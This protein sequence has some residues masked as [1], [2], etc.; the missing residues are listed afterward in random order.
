M[1]L[2][3]I[4]LAA[5]QGTRMRSQQPKVLHAIAGKSML[6]RVV[7]TAQQLNPQEIFVI[8]GY[9]GNLLR[10][11]LAHLNVTWVEQKEQLGTGHAVMQATPKIPDD[12]RVLV[13]YGD[14]PLISQ[15]TLEKLMAPTSK[16][17]IGMITAN[18]EDPA[19]L[20]RIVRDQSGNFIEIVEYK[21]A[22]EK[23]RS[24]HEINSGIYSFPA[25][26]LKAWLPKLSVENAQKEYYLTDVLAM[27]VQEGMAVATVFPNSDHEVMGVNDRVQLSTLERYYQAIQ[28]GNLMR[29]GVTMLDP[30]RVDIRGEVLTQGDV[31]VDINVIFEGQVTLGRGCIIESNCIVKNSWIG[32]NVLI[33]A[34]SM[35]EDS[36]VEADC[37]VGP[38]ARLRPGTHMKTK[39]RVGNFVEIKKSEIGEDSKVNHLSYIGDA[40]VGKNVNVGAG[41]ITC[42]YDGVNK[43]QTIIG[44]GAFI[45]SGTELVA[46][47]KVGEGA[48]IGA[49]STITMNAPNQQLTVARARQQTIQGWQPKVKEVK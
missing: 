39:S 33:K 44:D 26:N 35:L 4:I 41:T 38:F 34:N 47:V 48:F 24:I 17:S 6:E 1:K 16:K 10:A 20:G 36:R 27:A 43:H 30:A 13:L 45:G 31:T 19:E 22:T 2:S 49:G 37:H 18:L 3:V 25:H 12:H 11:R 21:D 8:Y 42:N 32:D 9:Q 28:V 5:G 23:Q 46:P 14:V 29:Q 7:N 40:T 15:G